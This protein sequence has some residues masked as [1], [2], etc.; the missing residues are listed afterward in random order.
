M[1]VMKVKAPPVLVSENWSNESRTNGCTLR[2]VNTK[3]AHPGVPMAEVSIELI[4]SLIEGP[5]G[6][7]RGT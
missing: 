4:A 2:W 6:S 7:V 5:L 3:L 1:P